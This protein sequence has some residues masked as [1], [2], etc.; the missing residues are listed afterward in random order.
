MSYLMLILLLQG[1]T[2]PEPPGALPDTASW[3][4]RLTAESSRPLTFLLPGTEPAQRL[5][6]ED[7]LWFRR[8]AESGGICPESGEPCQVKVFYDIRT[9]SDV[10]GQ[11]TQMVGKFIC[12]GPLGTLPGVVWQVREPITIHVYALGEDGWQSLDTYDVAYYRELKTFA[13]VQRYAL[14][15]ALSPPVRR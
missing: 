12:V 15:R 9:D 7:L 14:Q 3:P 4:A 11:Q 2:F 13:F 5:G 10:S 8:Y 1:P 6:T